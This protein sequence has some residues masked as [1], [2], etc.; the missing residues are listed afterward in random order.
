MPVHV[1]QRNYL[2]KSF[3][4][5]QTQSERVSKVISL[6]QLA[7]AQR[8]DGLSHRPGVHTGSYSILWSFS[9]SPEI[10]EKKSEF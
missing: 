1:S 8:S 3:N 7:E 9:A 4:P 6:S 2:K 5:S 10:A